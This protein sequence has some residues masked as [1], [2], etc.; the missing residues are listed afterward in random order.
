MR[1]DFDLLNKKESILAY[2]D[3]LHRLI[4]QNLD[5]MKEKIAQGQDRKKLR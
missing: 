3:D 5:E 2:M 1:K 4:K